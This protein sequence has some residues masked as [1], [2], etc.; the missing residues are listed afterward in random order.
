MGV[1]CTRINRFG[2]HPHAHGQLGTVTVVSAL[3]SVMSILRECD[4]ETGFAALLGRTMK[5][6]VFFQLGFIAA[7][8]VVVTA[9]TF[10]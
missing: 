10:L 2:H 6:L 9:L 4:I 3:R 7:I 8:I 1:G 5:E